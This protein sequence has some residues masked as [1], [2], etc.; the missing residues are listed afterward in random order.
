LHT[1]SVWTSTD[2]T[3]TFLPE[4]SH[5][6]AVSSLAASS[7]TLFPMSV[8]LNPT[9]GTGLPEESLIAS[10]V[11]TSATLASAAALETAGPMVWSG[12]VMAMPLAPAEMASLTSLMP[13]LASSLAL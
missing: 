1:E 4:V 12:T 2:S 5:P 11:A 8:P 6:A 3:P 10:S 7:P 13:V 9:K